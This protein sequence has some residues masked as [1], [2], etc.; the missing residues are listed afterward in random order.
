MIFFLKKKPPTTTLELDKMK[1]EK[2]MYTY[3]HPNSEIHVY[4]RV[5]MYDSGISQKEFW[6]TCTTQELDKRKHEIHVHVHVRTFW[7]L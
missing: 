1:S 7:K 2:Y 4:A 5:Y 6:N 3:V